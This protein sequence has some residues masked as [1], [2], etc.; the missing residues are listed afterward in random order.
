MSPASAMERLAEKLAAADLDEEETA[1]LVSLLA[2][3]NEDEVAGFALQK[4]QQT[5]VPTMQ[6]DHRSPA[7]WKNVLDA[8][9]STGCST[10]ATS[11]TDR[12]AGG[13]GSRQG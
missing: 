11:T 9:T 7:S 4:Q 1:L 2:G 13:A 12:A 6:L 8:P 3:S 10:A 5:A